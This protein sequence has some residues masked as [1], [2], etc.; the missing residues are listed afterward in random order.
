MNTTIIV[1]IAIAT[2]LVLG[3]MLL[4]ARP[5]PAWASKCAR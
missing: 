4:R 2:I 3:Y 5:M 1:I